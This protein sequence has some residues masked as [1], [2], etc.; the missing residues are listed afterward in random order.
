MEFMASFQKLLSLQGAL[1]YGHYGM[2]SP[3]NAE[4]TTVTTLPVLDSE[5]FMSCLDYAAND[6]STC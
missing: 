1:P 3:G 6:L 4:V 5:Y 2:P